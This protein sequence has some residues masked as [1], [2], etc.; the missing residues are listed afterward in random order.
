MG[1]N[2]IKNAAYELTYGENKVLDIIK[3]LY[4]HIEN[5]VYI[6]VQPTIAK[7]RP[8]FI[9]L[10][11][12]RRISIFE[13]KDWSKSYIK[14]VSKTRVELEDRTEDNPLYKL[15]NYHMVISGAIC[16]TLQL[17]D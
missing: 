5:E 10:D 2:V 6:Y 15:K 1:I 7:L 14:K 17:Y 16:T 12:N 11:S 8:D 9:I 3:D 4:K 13:I